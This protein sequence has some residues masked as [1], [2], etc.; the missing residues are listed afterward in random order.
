MQPPLSTPNPRR[1]EREQSAAPVEST[2][3]PG[4][5]TAERVTKVQ[6]IEQESLQVTEKLVQQAAAIEQLK[7]QVS[8]EAAAHCAILMMPLACPA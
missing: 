3:F 6:L 8:S 1:R 4:Q 7:Q 5:V 2:F